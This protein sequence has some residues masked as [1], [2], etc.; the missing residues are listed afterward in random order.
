MRAREIQ[1]RKLVIFDID[2]TLVHTQTKVHV[3]KDNQVINSLNSHDFT[4]YKLQPGESFDFGDFRDAREFF[5]K[6]KP[7]IPMINQLKRDIATGNKVVMVTARSDFDDREL[8]LD[9]FRKYGVDMSRV[10][11]YRAGNMTQKVQTEE[12]KKII[13][14]E[15]LNKE[16]YTKAIMYDDAEPNLH[17]FISLK[18][19]YPHTKFYAWH[20][21][22]DGEASEYHRTDETVAEAK[23]RKRKPRWAAYGPGPYGMYGT[24]VGYSGD[25]G[26]D[27]GGGESIK[28]E[29]AVMG[30]IEDSGKIV[31]ILKKAHTV[32]FSD[33]KNWLLI[34]TD[35]AKGNKGLGLKWV[36]ADTRFE[37]VRPYRDTT[38]EN[39][40]DGKNPQDKGDSKRHGVPTKAS[41]STLRK[42]A[43]QG[44]RKGQLA[45]WMANMKAGKAKKK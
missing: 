26:G 32:P 43:K 16:L 14:R 4:H 11:V 36:P 18:D 3:V 31:R 7:I 1:P 30:K 5:E 37:W 38:D 6:S 21:S 17:A 9:T 19:E 34:D 23:K 29:D 25:G 22:L 28:N 44:G 15:L 8:F 12:K 35:P 33:E 13:I 42:V 39:F 27:G 40:A 20:V 2:D 41:V 45:H 24:A 10:H